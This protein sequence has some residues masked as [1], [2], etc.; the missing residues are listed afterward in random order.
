M[1]THNI[2]Y[3]YNITLWQVAT[4]VTGTLDFCYG[5]PSAVIPKHFFKWK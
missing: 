2:T 3:M 1:A 5:K 4:S